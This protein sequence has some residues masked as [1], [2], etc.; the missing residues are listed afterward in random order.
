MMKRRYKNQGGSGPE[1]S[2]IAFS[3]TTDMRGKQAINI[4]F[5]VAHAKIDAPDNVILDAEQVAD[6]RDYLLKICPCAANPPKS[7]KIID[8]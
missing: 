5:R 1:Y 4:T 7:E 3:N 2:S 8:E 6:L